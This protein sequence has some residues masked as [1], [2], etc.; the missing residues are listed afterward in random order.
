MKADL[1][2]RAGIAQTLDKRMAI[3][4]WRR[5]LTAAGDPGDPIDRQTGHPEIPGS[6]ASGECHTANHE[7]CSAD[8]GFREAYQQLFVRLN[9]VGVPALELQIVQSVGITPNLLGVE[10][11]DDDSALKQFVDTIRFDCHL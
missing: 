7:P 9:R 1:L 8:V 6:G 10:R 5:H 4:Q 2:V 3:P 11:Q